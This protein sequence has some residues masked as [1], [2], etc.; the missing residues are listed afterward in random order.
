MDQGGTLETPYFGTGD[1][2]KAEIF[3]LGGCNSAPRSSREAPRG[4]QTL[5]RVTSFLTLLLTF[6]GTGRGQA[7]SI[8]GNQAMLRQGSAGLG[9][10]LFAGKVRFRNGGPACASCHSIAGI[11]F[12]NGGTLGPDLTNAYQ[13]LGPQGMQPAMETLFFR[14]MTPI[15]DQHP[16]TPEEQ[17]DLI[18]FFQ[19]AASGRA[20]RGNTQIIAGIS[21]AGCVL[22]LVI[23]NAVWHDRLKSVRR[24]LVERA[25]RQEKIS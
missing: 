19:E 18:A 4:R 15:Y 8:T 25:R 24:S 3:E 14:V 7:S 20:P 22:L 2:D 11:P 16:L 12:P 23:A 17:S 21:L 10:A 13:K 5:F 9:E 1:R 6:A